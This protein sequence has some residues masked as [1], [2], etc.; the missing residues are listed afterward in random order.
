MKKYYAFVL[1]VF[2]AG[3]SI[4]IILEHFLTWGYLEWELA[5]HETY[6]AVL[7]VLSLI[8]MWVTKER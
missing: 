8:V 1:A 4:A 2:V 6:G 5:G 7:L 3:G